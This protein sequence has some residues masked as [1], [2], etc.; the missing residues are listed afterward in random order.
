MKISK[1]FSAETPIYVYLSTPNLKH[2]EFYTETEESAK[3][4][5]AKL[6]E[7]YGKFEDICIMDART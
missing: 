5:V 6:E 2:I 7:S 1:N 4:H 3:I